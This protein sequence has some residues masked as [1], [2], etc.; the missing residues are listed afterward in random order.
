MAVLEESGR[1]GNAVGDGNP[2]QRDLEFLMVYAE[3]CK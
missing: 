2:G 1:A 3:A